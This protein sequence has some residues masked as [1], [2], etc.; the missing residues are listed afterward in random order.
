PDGDPSNIPYDGLSHTMGTATW[1]SGVPVNYDRI[2]L[3]INDAVECNNLYGGNP[4]TCFVLPGTE[5]LEDVCSLKACKYDD[6]DAS[7]TNNTGDTNLSGWTMT[8]FDSS[9]TQ[10]TSGTTGTDGCVT[11]DNLTPGTYTVTETAP[12][13]GL[14]WFNTDPGP[15]CLLSGSSSVGYTACST[16]PSKSATVVVN[17]TAGVSFGNI[18]SAE[19]D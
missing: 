14:P 11:F 4:G 10:L 16:A 5:P 3:H 2:V 13:G 6:K 17:Q 18:Q 15:L 9:N 12:S 8:V 19:K 7:G 1:N